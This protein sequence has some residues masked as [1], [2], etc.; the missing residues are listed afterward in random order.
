[1][2]RSDP[3]WYARS[4][5][6]CHIR[7]GHAMSTQGSEENEETLDIVAEMR[8]GFPEGYY[9]HSSGEVRRAKVVGAR[10]LWYEAEFDT[11]VGVETR[12]KAN[13]RRI[14]EEI[15]FLPNFLP[16]V[17]ESSI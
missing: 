17:G 10:V 8:I 15:V 16:A 2:Y 5:E 13:S 6:R 12:S 11:F 7:K 1:M 4:N 9:R 3:M 14:L